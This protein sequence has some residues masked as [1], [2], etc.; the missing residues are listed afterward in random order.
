MTKPA[1]QEANATNVRPALAAG[2]DPFGLAPWLK[3][4]PG[5]PLHPLMAH[6]MAAIAAGT[7]IGFGI[8][9]QFAGMMLGAMQG[10]TDRAKVSLDRAQA[11][12]AGT[13]PTVVRDE[14]VVATKDK[15]L[16]PVAIPATVTKAKAVRTKARPVAEPE[17][18][19]RTIRA[20]SG[21]KAAR[22]DDL[23]VI[24][25]VGPKLEQ[26]LNG[27]G[28][29]RYADIAA[30]TASDVKRIEAELGLDG[31]IARDGWVEQAGTL[32]K[33]RG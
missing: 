24:S 33:A 15:V 6:P 21:S 19:A 14:P 23:K 26:V 30:W 25:G 11:E 20:S 17:T 16:E 12:G 7:A 8:A 29:S 31:R 5:M 27:M 13:K 32:A 10:A 28:I 18:K 22:T 4:M 3:E 9:G 1:G 2:D